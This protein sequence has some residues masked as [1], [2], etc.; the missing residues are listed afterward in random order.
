[1]K[2]IIMFNHNAR[3]K[4]TKN[5]KVINQEIEKDKDYNH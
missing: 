1:M 4:N 3:N 2:S 5:K